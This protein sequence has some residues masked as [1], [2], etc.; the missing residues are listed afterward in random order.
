[1]PL[2]A[3]VRS[4]GAAWRSDRTPEEQ[5]E[6]QAHAVHMKQLYEAGAVVLGGWLDDTGDVLLI[7]RG[8]SRDEVLH[9]LQDD[10]WT[11]LGVLPVSRVESW[12]LGLGTLAAAGESA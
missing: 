11:G 6:F 9:Q 12:S 4:R 3:V 5:P 2:F 8:A 7:M 10:P 1:V